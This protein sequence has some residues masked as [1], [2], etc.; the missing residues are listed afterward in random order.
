M[1]STLAS[2]SLLMRTRSEK[3]TYIR[4]LLEFGDRWADIG[5]VNEYFANDQSHR[6][7]LH[8]FIETKYD[9]NNKQLGITHLRFRIDLLEKLKVD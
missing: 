1:P 6:I 9:P 3:D 2:V 8:K 5:K 4:F 7:A